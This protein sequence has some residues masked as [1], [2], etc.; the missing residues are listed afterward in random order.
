MAIKMKLAVVVAGRFFVT[1]AINHANS[2][3]SSKHDTFEDTTRPA[4]CTDK[5]TGIFVTWNFFCL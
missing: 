3:S 2:G 1:V 4:V 5:T